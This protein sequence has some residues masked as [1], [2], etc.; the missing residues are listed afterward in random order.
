MFYFIR[1]SYDLRL[2]FYQAFNIYLVILELKD[3]DQMNEA[4]FVS[5]PPPRPLFFSVCPS[6]ILD[7]L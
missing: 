5:E 4:F 7:L 3:F 1:V 6:P 2:G